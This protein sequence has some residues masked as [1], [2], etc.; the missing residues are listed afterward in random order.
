M[1]TVAQTCLARKLC[2]TKRLASTCLLK[3]QT[4][5]NAQKVDHHPYLKGRGVGVPQFHFSSLP[6]KREN[7]TI[8]I[9]FSLGTYCPAAVLLSAP[10]GY[11]V[12]TVKRKAALCGTKGI[13]VHDAAKSGRPK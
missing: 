6:H 10:L 1:W 7:W 2:K 4:K 11:Y 9:L 3:E 13:A 12:R 8:T 5:T